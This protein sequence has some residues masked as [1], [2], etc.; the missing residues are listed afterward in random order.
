VVLMARD[1]IACKSVK[2]RPLDLFGWV[3]GF[4]M[5]ERFAGASFKFLNSVPWDNRDGK[6]ARDIASDGIDLPSRV[7]GG[8]LLPSSSAN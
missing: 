8:S 6:E 5:N 3:S 7:S 1:V 4:P 2:D